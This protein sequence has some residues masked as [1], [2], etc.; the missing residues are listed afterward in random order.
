MP[1]LSSPNGRAPSG[2]SSVDHMPK[3]RKH[4]IHDCGRR[5]HILLSPTSANQIF[6][7]VHLNRHLFNVQV[8]ENAFGLSRKESQRMM[9][10]LREMEQISTDYLIKTERVNELT[11]G[12]VRSFKE[13][14]STETIGDQ[15]RNIG[16][17][18]G[19]ALTCSKS[20]QRLSMER[21]CLKYIPNWR[22]T[23]PRSSANY[24]CFWIG[25]IA[26]EV[27][28][29][30]SNCISLLKKVYNVASKEFA[31]RATLD[32]VLGD[33]PIGIASTTTRCKEQVRVGGVGC[34]YNPPA[35]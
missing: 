8:V 9:T 17:N 7:T 4:T 30:V 6:K 26:Y 13:N 15:I 33:N 19:C 25:I 18:D 27:T 14:L 10:N 16:L 20:R 31:S 35:R 12:F 29:S 28:N 22:Q 32:S 1:C 3:L 23:S 24:A 5:T 2:D 21:H 34:N 11:S